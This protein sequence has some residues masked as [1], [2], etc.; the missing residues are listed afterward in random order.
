MGEK[1]IL[2]DYSYLCKTLNLSNNLV[3]QIKMEGKKWALLKNM[4]K[5]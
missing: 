5:N 1:W 2:D 3:G 4:R